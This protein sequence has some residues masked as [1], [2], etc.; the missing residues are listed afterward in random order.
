MI[1]YFIAEYDTWYVFYD[2]VKEKPKSV[3]GLR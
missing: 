3:F 1:E 2:V